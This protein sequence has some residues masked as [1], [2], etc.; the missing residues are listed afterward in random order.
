MRVP[1]RAL[2][3]SAYLVISLLLLVPI[4]GPAYPLVVGAGALLLALFAAP[5][6]FAWSPRIRDIAALLAMYLT[7]VALFYVA[8]QVV[9]V[10]SEMVLFVVFGAGLLLGVIGPLVHVVAV[11]GRPLADLG[12][13]RA[14]LPMTLALSVVLAV[15]QA[16]ITFPL[17]TFGAPDSWLPLLVLA[18]TV[19][20]F[21]AIFF[22][23]YMLA[24][25][26]PMLGVMP[27]VAVAALL[28]ALYHAGYGMG[29]EEMLFLGGLGLVYT[30]AYALARNVFVLWPLLTPLGSFFANVRG[31]EIE[32]PMIAILG[33][34]DVLGLMAAAI[35]ITWRWT[36][37][38]LRPTTAPA[39]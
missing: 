31:G 22:R 21:E 5:R 33:F 28:Y 13:T 1:M 27:A 8:F 14:R 24:I 6:A 11:Q 25:L 32:M 37:Q 4:A 12:L 18:L 16:A 7:C 3:W 39:P 23:G 15:L 29:S 17:V 10:G 26:E 20:F 34:V 30:I 35:Y 36:R 9:T 38:R 2:L 19:G